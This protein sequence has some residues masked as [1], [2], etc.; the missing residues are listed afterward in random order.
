MRVLYI[1]VL[2]FYV[3]ILTVSVMVAKVSLLVSMST[4]K[5]W[6]QTW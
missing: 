2:C 6:V 1:S 3:D 4:S 5:M